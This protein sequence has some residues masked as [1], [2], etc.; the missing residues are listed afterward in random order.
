MLFV[1]LDVCVIVVVLSTRAAG[2]TAA[3]VKKFCLQTETYNFENAVKTRQL[4][5]TVLP[6]N[7]FQ[8]FL[9][10]TIYQKGTPYSWIETGFSVQISYL[11]L[12][13]IR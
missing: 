6:E 10:N 4:Y 9:L 11:F 5:S 8:L 12:N 1:C 7:L 13:N 2:R 3:P